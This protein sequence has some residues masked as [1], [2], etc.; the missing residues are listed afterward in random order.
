MRVLLINCETFKGCARPVCESYEGSKASNE[1]IIADLEKKYKV[2]DG[3]YIIYESMSEFM[4]AF[5][6]EEMPYT[7][8][9]LS[10]LI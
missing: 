8:H 7:T 5:N 2:E 1:D 4:D 3:D 10:Y 9:F 6:N